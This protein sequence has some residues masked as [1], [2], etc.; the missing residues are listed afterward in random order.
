MTKA[1]R[2]KSSTSRPPPD[3]RSGPR[4][5][6]RSSS[7][8]F[9]ERIPP[10]ARPQAAWASMI[11]F[12]SLR[13]CPR[14]IHKEVGPRGPSRK[15][16][17]YRRRHQ[18]RNVGFRPL[19]P[20]MRIQ[21]IVDL[22]LHHE[23]GGPL[24]DEGPDEPDYDALPGRHLGNRE[25]TLLLPMLPLMEP[26]HQS[27]TS[28]EV[29]PISGAWMVGAPMA[30]LSSTADRGFRPHQS[31]NFIE[32]YRQISSRSTTCPTPP[33]YLRKVRPWRGYSHQN[34]IGRIPPHPR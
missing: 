26:N 12:C 14:S 3:S 8:T 34:R 33:I 2:A 11:S 19:S 29:S 27:A 13:I 30:S 15:T 10:S 22:Q 23:H 5:P 17:T 28:R 9:T 18:K 16:R 7:K 6:L 32:I 1:V 31:L 25:G 21:R 4:A 24:V 20:L